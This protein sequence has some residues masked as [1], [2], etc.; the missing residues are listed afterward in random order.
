LP[1]VCISSIACSKNSNEIPILEASRSGEFSA[2]L[3]GSVDLAIEGDQA[4]RPELP[5]FNFNF[6]C[7]VVATNNFSE[8]N[9]L[10]EGG[11]GRVYKVNIYPKLVF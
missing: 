2:D 8:E 4:N 10:G 9:K 5:L 6:N 1:T 7:V 3:S 11:F